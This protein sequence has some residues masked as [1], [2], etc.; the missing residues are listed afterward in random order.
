LVLDLQARRLSVDGRVIDLPP[1]SFDYLTVLARH[2]PEVAAALAA[3]EE[4]VRQQWVDPGEQIVLFNTGSGLNYLD[5]AE[6]VK[7]E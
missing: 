5:H 3:L 4:L 2:A 6:E 1:A 7:R